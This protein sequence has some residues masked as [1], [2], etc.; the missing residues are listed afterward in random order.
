MTT[1]WLPHQVRKRPGWANAR[2]AEWLYKELVG[3]RA[4]RRASSRDAEERPTFTKQ[5][6]ISA[7]LAF[8]K[9]RPPPNNGNKRLQPP[10][11]LLVDAEGEDEGL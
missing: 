4:V 6:A 7:L 10:N 11:P 5:D 8:D 2:D 1:D 3:W 9:L